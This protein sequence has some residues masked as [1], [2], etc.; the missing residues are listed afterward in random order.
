MNCLIITGANGGIGS[1]ICQLYKKKNWYIIGLDLHA[2]KKNNYIDQYY[3]VNL[4][5]SEEI[6]NFMDKVDKVNCF[7]HCAAYQL[8]KPIWE[9]SEQEWDNSYKCNVKSIFLFVK[10]GIEI[11]KT[12]KTNIINIG[13]IHFA[14]TSKNIAAYAST[15]S[16]L[17]GLTRNMAIDLAQFGIRVNSISPGAIDTPML[18]Q[19]L[20]SDQLDILKDNHLLKTIG[21]PMQI[22]DTCYFINKN[23]FFNGNNII[24]DGGILAQLSSE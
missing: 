22:A 17:V 3:K 15:K 9:Y 5:N 19:H 8:C 7:I 12:S 21:T 16:A 24:I 1:A 10:Y 13:S 18:N 2:N 6:K 20:T 11:F 23:T 14:S 4:F